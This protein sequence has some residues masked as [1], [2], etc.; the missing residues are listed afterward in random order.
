VAKVQINGETFQFDITRKPM[1]EALAIEHALNCRYADWETDMQGGSARALCGF[2]WLVW[3]RDGRD[4][5]LADILSGD[6]DVD[7]A[8]LDIELEP[9]EPG[10]EQQEQG[11]EP[12]D[13]TSP[14]PAVSSSTGASTSG[15]SLKSSPSGR[16]SSGGS[17]SPSSKR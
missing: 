4:I 8:T 14:G 17:P 9:G 7:L 2:I 11:G 16:G 3:R 10:Y 15:R 1:S 12:V 6:V 5:A 13:P